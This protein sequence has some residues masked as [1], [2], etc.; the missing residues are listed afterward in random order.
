MSGLLLAD[1]ERG[2]ILDCAFTCA[3]DPMHDELMEAVREATNLGRRNPLDSNRVGYQAGSLMS[4][5]E[6]NRQPIFSCF[7]FAAE[8]RLHVGTKK[9]SRTLGL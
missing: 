2:H 9:V 6:N 7:F 3:F 4:G 8:G 5:M 1:P